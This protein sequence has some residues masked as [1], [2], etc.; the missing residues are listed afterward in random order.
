MRSLDLE[1]FGHRLTV[2]TDADP[3]RVRDVVSFVNYRLEAIQQSSRKV[4]TDHIA[5]L[6][7]LNIAEEL[8][9]ARDHVSTLRKGVREKARRLLER[10]D[11]VA[12][13]VELGPRDP[14]TREVT[15]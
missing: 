3:D 2:N 13:E 5:L 10:I 9:E 15:G 4:Q 6:A 14:A 7:A 12:H 8:F 11:R 1:V